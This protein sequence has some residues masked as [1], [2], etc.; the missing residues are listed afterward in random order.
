MILKRLKK[1]TETS[2]NEY[3][4]NNDW[5]YRFLHLCFQ[6]LLFYKCKFQKLYGKTLKYVI[7]YNSLKVL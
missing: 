7:K 3:N 4:L 5:W 6:S 2:E 1:Q